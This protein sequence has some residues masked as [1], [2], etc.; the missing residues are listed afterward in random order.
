MLVA[1]ST[2][3]LVEQLVGW[4]AS[5]IDERSLR[6]GSRLPS[7]RGLAEAQGVS[8]FTVVEAYD[9]LIAKGY[10]EARKGS[11]FFVRPR[12]EV[13]AAP[14]SLPWADAPIQRIDVVWLLRNMFR[15]MAP[16]DMPG[17]GVLPADWLSA[18]LVSGSVRALGRQDTA[19]LLDY[20]EPQGFRPLREQLRLKLAEIDIAATGERI[21]TTAGVTQ[22]LD[23]IAQTLLEPGDTV[24]VD[25]PSWFLMFGR[26]AMLGARVI[27]VPRGID[28][29]DIERLRELAAAHRPKM[30]VVVSALHNPTSASMSSGR[31]FQVL[32]IA[33]EFGFTLVE[34]DVYG[35]LHPGPGGQACVRLAALDQLQRVVYLGGFSKTLAANL[36][37]GFVAANED[38]I[39][40]MT[41]L[42]ML[43]GLTS[44]ELGERIV[45][46]VLTEGHYRRHVE[47]LKS[48]LA[49]SRDT[50]VREL[51]RLG[52]SVFGAPTA[53]MFVW[54]DAGTDTLPV[55]QSMLE[56][57][58]LMAPGSLFLPDQRPSSW[59]RFNVA[60]SRNP[61]MLELLDR[62]LQASAR[63]EPVSGGA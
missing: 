63:R 46:R 38:L 35:D 42:K 37:V 7:I 8:K 62:Q 48:R 50:T 15:K 47:R 19:A 43:I 36:R 1:G 14:A 32:R 23:L 59:M 27:G 58:F 54:A 18:E 21:L 41:D 57:G 34:D 12:P 55:A 45:H 28:G 61:R 29:P 10:I 49:R 25:E 56:A 26:F 52:L 31:A 30:F 24:L 60:T 39:R 53:G 17:A 13:L 33:E 4:F 5:R 51:E 11:G 9:R 20:G 44:P 6:G 40:R 16:R 22:G 3:T 2:S